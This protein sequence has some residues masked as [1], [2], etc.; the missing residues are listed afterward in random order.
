[1]VVN[2]RPRIDVPSAHDRRENRNPLLAFTY[3]PTQCAP[4][5]KARHARRRGPLTRDETSCRLPDYA[6]DEM[7]VALIQAR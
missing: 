7:A 5:L 3:E 4:G 1:M 2:G 6:D